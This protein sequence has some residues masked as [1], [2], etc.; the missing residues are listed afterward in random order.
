MNSKVLS[1]V[2]LDEEALLSLGDLC[3]ACSRHAEWIVELVDEGILQPTGRYQEQWR[4]P[5]TSLQRAQTALRLQEDLHINLA[6]VALALDLMD[7][8]ESLR[9]L[10]CRLE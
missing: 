4:F 1:G 3:Q 9:A 5:G 10:V 8:I 2:V 7:E 6:G